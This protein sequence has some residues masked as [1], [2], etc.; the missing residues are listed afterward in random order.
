MPGVKVKPPSI[1]LPV[2]ASTTVPVTFSGGATVTTFSS[3]A[4]IATRRLSMNPCLRKSVSTASAGASFH[5]KRPS[6]SV[7]RRTSNARL[8]RHVSVATM[9]PESWLALLSTTRPLSTLTASSLNST[10][11]AQE[12]RL[13]QADHRIDNVRGNQV[14]PPFSGG[15]GGDLFVPVEAADPVIRRLALTSVGHLNLRAFDCLAGNVGN[16]A[17]DRRAA[18]HLE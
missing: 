4:L 13:G 9:T 6:A 7:L 3:P 10:S 14:L 16:D 5:V 2:S 8:S 11:C 12:G 18:L 1:G 15:V 17:A